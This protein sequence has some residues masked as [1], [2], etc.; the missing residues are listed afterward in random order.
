MY[1]HF[2]NVLFTCFVIFL[3]SSHASALSSLK[4]NRLESANFPFLKAYVSVE[5]DGIVAESVSPSD[6]KISV[7]GKRVA[8][9]SITS[10]QN[11]GESVAM[12]LAVDTSG[13]M[14]QE[15]LSAIKKAIASLV[16]QKGKDDIAALISFNDD[17]TPE[18]DFTK[19]S[20]EFLKKLDALKIKGKITVLFKALEYGLD[21]LKKT[22]NL[23]AIRYLIVLSDGKDEGEGFT[24]QSAV[25]KAKESHIP[26]YTLG[27]VSRADAKYLDNMVFLAK[28]T[29][30]E[31]RKI[32]II[33]DFMSAYSDI[34]GKIFKQQVVE[35]KA[36]FEGDGRDHN[37]EIQYAKDGDICTGRTAF[38]APDL[39][40]PIET[41]DKP[42]PGTEP[43]SESEKQWISGIPN[44]FLII[45]L[46]LLIILT[47]SILIV[48]QM[49]KP[50]PE[51]LHSNRDEYI[52]EEHEEWKEEP[53]S[54][55]DL[56]DSSEKPSAPAEIK[57]PLILDIPSMGITFPLSIGIMTIGA[58]PDNSLVLDR[59]T[60]SGY[61]AEIS[62]NGEEWILKDLGST[63]G[64]R[65]NGER[66]TNPAVIN[67]GDMIRIGPFE[68]KVTR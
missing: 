14:K 48:T 49:I 16:S 12:V 32:K 7:E 52:P 31:Y 61:H 25:S 15:Q 45:G 30:G 3:F 47:F 18:C 63:N 62:G 8:V 64:T 36:D 42:E 13:S 39:V 40:K 57:N 58:Y 34:A 50:K 46:I 65:L 1:Q 27:F 22:P 41:P 67:Q 37:L 35:M 56:N 59:D 5:Q 33:D 28:E 19:D 53:L 23:P 60:V 17:V 51:P 4:I 26:V 29:D 10:L 55:Y 38:F 9:K 24:L 68:I 44:N 2:K 11:S 6:I 20:D 21:R 66:I 43:V 54:D